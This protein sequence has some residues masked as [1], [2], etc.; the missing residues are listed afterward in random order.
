MDGNGRSDFLSQLLA[1]LE[2]YKAT[3]ASAQCHSAAGTGTGTGTGHQGGA[4]AGASTGAGAQ[5][6]FAGLAA[7]GTSSAADSAKQQQHGQQ[8]TQQQH[9]QG[10]PWPLKYAPVASAH[11]CGGGGAVG[12]LKGW[13]TQWRDV[14][15]QEAAQGPEA[16]G[17]AGK[18]KLMEGAGARSGM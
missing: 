4:G 12:E 16:G 6:L 9:R 3:A 10:L 7:R 5:G 14:I 11:L 17:G 2:Q 18:G 8:Q 1:E 13:L 15:A